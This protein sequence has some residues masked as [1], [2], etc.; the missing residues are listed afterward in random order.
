ME[1]E[2]CCGGGHCACHDQHM[3]KKEEESMCCGGHCACHENHE[4]KKSVK[5]KEKSS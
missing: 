2:N 4:E 1:Q 3:D 5:D